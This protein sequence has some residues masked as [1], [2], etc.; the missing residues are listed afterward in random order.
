MRRAG[1]S[2]TVGDVCDVVDKKLIFSRGST[3]GGITLSGGEPLAPIH[4]PFVRNVVAHCVKMGIPIA[5]ETSGAWPRSDVIN[6]DAFLGCVDLYY[7]DTKCPA[8]TAAGRSVPADL[9]G[10][11]IKLSMDNL[12]HVAKMPGMA[13]RIVFSVPLIPGINASAADAD[14]L[15]ALAHETGV[16]RVRL[17]PYHT[18]ARD[19]YEQ[20]GRP[21]TFVP[22]EASL[23]L[24]EAVATMH[25][26][27]VQ[28]GLSIVE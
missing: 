3:G 4:A 27:L 12:R 15:I 5:V 19:K 6:D 7:W 20:L 25:K 21:Y 13:D 11:A 17:L 10:E 26:L 14:A 2:M 9:L 1:R 28:G 8:A 24:E 16:T 22:P 23:P 18:M